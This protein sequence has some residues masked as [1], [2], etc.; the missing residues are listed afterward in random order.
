MGLGLTI[1]MLAVLENGEI[2]NETTSVMSTV[3]VLEPVTEVHDQFLRWGS[4]D[5]AF[6]YVIVSAAALLQDKSKLRLLI[7]LETV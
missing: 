2:G 4:V 1:D 3:I 6:R 5:V 7:V